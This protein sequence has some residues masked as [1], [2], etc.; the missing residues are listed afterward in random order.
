MKYPKRRCSLFFLSF[1]S[2]LLVPSFGLG[3][4][5]LLS[6]LLPLLSGLLRP[7]DSFLRTMTSG[8]LGGGKKSF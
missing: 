2:S 3:L 7:V 1:S 5:P 8:V 6:G 4:L